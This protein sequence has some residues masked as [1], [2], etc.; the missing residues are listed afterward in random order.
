MMGKILNPCHNFEIW[1]TYVSLEWF[2]CRGQL[3]VP[4]HKSSRES[5]NVVYISWPHLDDQVE[6]YQVGGIPGN[7]SFEV[8]LR[9]I[10]THSNLGI[11]LFYL[12]FEAPLVF[13]SETNSERCYKLP[14]G[15]QNW[16]SWKFIIF[17]Y[18]KGTLSVMQ[19]NYP[20]KKNFLQKPNLIQNQ[21]CLDA[22]QDGFCKD[23]TRGYPNMNNK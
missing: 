9:L 16:I 21:T 1:H 6:A 10:H 11:W 3:A 5:K 17:R 18:K 19:S 7:L 14:G 12:I 23:K 2:L 15:Q 4:G 22:N 13:L 8:T 20:Q